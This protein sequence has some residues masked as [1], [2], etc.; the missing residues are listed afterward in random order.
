MRFSLFVKRLS[1][2]LKR[3]RKSVC[4]EMMKGVSCLSVLA[5]FALASVALGLSTVPLPRVDPGAKACQLLKEAFP[6][7]VAF[8][9]S[10]EYEA[11][12]EH[13]ASTSTQDASCSV[14]PETADDV[15]RILKIVGR[16]DIMSPFAV[17]GG[18]HAFNVGHSS[19]SGVQISMAKFSDVEIDAEK[20][21]VTIGTGLTW[22]QVYSQLEPLGVMVVGGRVIGVGVAGLSLGGG[23]SWKTDQFGLTIDTIV[24]HNVV[25]PS[26]QQVHASNATNPDL[27]FGL[28]GG[29]NNFGI[30]T[31]ITF[32]AHPQTLVFGGLITYTLNVTDGVNEAIS[33]FEANNADPK[34]QILVEFTSTAGQFTS[35]V[36]IFYDRPTPPPGLFDAFLSIPP[37]TSDVK[38]R[39]FIDFIS[40]S[41]NITLAPNFGDVHHV[42][43]LL[44]HPVA[45]LRTIV[46]E[47]I[48]TE[49]ELTKANNGKTVS[50]NM[51]PEPF[52][53]PFAHSRGGAYPH[54][55]ARPVKPGSPDITWEVDA[56]VSE[57]AQQ[58]FHALIIHTMHTFAHTIQSAAVELGISSF[59]DILY[60]NYALGD[61]PLALMYG[62]AENVGKLREIAGRFDPHGV[63]KL[64][65]RP[66]F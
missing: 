64:S 11:D 26:G 37:L 58:A 48:S 8:P 44:S 34:A 61:T 14:E 29:L 45:L 50:V 33:N 19:T 27:F 5:S 39:T 13:W 7:L 65:G 46:Q 25:L 35:G 6:Q 66:K 9:G 30:V 10:E 40:T 51:V 4:S 43:P 56:S 24:S 62:G 54:E 32:E 63:M 42:V 15:S 16:S 52:L 60:P 21:T 47:I 17:K 53:N 57:E 2:L 28:R 49:A 1:L 12:I 20:G 18:G 59:T 41:G 31:N 23:Y 36:I 3:G 38:T 55:A 22:D